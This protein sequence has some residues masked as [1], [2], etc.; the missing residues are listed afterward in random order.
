MCRKR[1]PNKINKR[2][3]ASDYQGKKKGKGHKRLDRE[4]RIKQRKMRDGKMGLA[5]FSRTWEQQY[6]NGTRC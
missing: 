2:V 5:G 3:D 6:L 1:E 4:R